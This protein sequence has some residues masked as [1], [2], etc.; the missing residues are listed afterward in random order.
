MQTDRYEEY[1]KLKELVI[2]KDELV[3]VRATPPYYLKVCC[4]S[5][6]LSLRATITSRSSPLLLATAVQIA[7]T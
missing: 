5:C 3:A 4:F 6:I 7:K 1:P 2:R